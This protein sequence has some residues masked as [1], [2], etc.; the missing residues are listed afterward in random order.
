MI[1]KSY[2]ANQNGWMT[3]EI[4][5]KWFFENRFV[6]EATARCNSVGLDRDCKILL[7]LDN[8]PAHANVELV[9]SNVCTVRLRPS[10]TSPIQPPDNGILR[11]LKCKYCA[12]FMM[13]LLS[14][15]NSGRP[16]Q[17]FLKTFNLRSM[18]LRMLGNLSR[19]RL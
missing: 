19:P 17:E 11:S 16:V 3:T 6:P 1:T 5:S 4:S 15:S 18:V 12:I 2:R 10:C 9:K 13:R 14:A 8:C 7:I